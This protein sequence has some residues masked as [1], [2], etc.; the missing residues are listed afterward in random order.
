MPTVVQSLFGAARKRSAL[1]LLS[2]AMLSLLVLLTNPFGSVQAGHLIVDPVVRVYTV[3]FATSGQSQIQPGLATDNPAISDKGFLFEWGISVGD[4]GATLEHKGIITVDIPGAITTAFGIED[5]TGTFGGGL[6][7]G[8]DGKFGLGL[9]IDSNAN[10]DLSVDYPVD[11][12]L[13][14]PAAESF[15]PGAT[16][17]ISSDWSLN[18]G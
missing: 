7:A 15:R 9:S 3:D 4:V 1:F 10:S 13:V 6:S 5:I 8:T 12:A 2:S 18:S 11:I 17:T 14:I 16:I